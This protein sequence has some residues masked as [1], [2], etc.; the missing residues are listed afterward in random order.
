M[1]GMRPPPAI[2]PRPGRLERAGLPSVPTPMTPQATMTRRD[3]RS[4]LARGALAAL[5]ALTVGA[6]ACAG[7]R[8]PGGTLAELVAAGAFS[9]GGAPAEAAQDRPLRL[10]GEPRPGVVT[11]DDESRPAVTFPAGTWSWRTRVPEDGWLQV[12][13][14]AV[15]GGPLEASVA[16]SNGAEREVLEVGRNDPPEDEPE[17]RGW[18]D[19][20]ADLSRWAGRQVTLDFTVRRP[21]A[22]GAAPDVAWGPVALTAPR[23]VGK[24]DPPNV[25]F[26]LVDTLRHD[27]TTPYGYARDTTPEI[28]RLLARRGTVLENAYSQAPWTLPSVVSFMTSRYPG[29]ILGSDPASYGIPPGVEPIAAAFAALGYRTGAFIGNP[30]VHAGN[31]FARGFETFYS[32]SSPEAITRHGE[33]LNRRALPWLRAHQAERF[34]AYVHYVDPH[35][36]YDD[37]DVVGGRSRLF[38]DPGGMPPTYLQGV[39]AGKLYPDNLE[40]EVRHF[41]A[42]YDTEVHWVDGAI[43]KLLESLPPEVLAH[44]LVVLTADHGEELHD[45]G[46]WKHGQT[47]YEDQIHVPL[48]V[49][50]DGRIQA[51][52]RLSGTVRLVDLLPTLVAA[53]GGRPD[54]SWQGRDLLGPFEGRAPLPRLEAFAQRLQ[55]GPLRAALVLDGRKL[56]LFNRR[57]PF[58]PQDN[59]QASLYRLNLSRM[60]GTELYDLR[61]DPVE[62][63][64][65]LAPDSRPDPGAAPAA[66]DSGRTL[67]V[68]DSLL[69]AHVA[70]TFRFLRALVDSLPAGRRLAGELVFERPPSQVIPLFLSDRDRATS[71]GTTVSFDLVG[72]GRAKGF[73]IAGEPGALLS[74][75]LTLDGEPLA[76]ARLRVGAGE[77]F[78]GRRVEPGALL[79]RAFPAAS[80]RP[81]LRLWAYAGGSEPAA[82]ANPETRKGLEALGYVQ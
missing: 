82:A 80:D 19:F 33:S 35:D 54:P 53:A 47:V 48:I 31:G 30:I 8:P 45:H 68:L 36:P 46:G 7:R 37:P 52:R 29:E 72:E 26:I 1:I 44:T 58:T 25:L 13:V 3:S 5:L 2:M 10:S 76:P 24:T 17:V 39:Y 42:L 21:G 27:H 4:F 51:A 18:I 61:R 75:N 50:W 34:F 78:T 74:A 66:E 22:P 67:A 9:A 16:L 55:V 65:L 6:G 38:D 81:G 32:P 11:L 69:Q 71:A 28:E 14:G 49:R 56:I 15:D 77:P 43:G 60:R 20:G 73:A 59:L 41:T 57:E 62:R 63:Q 23:P 40:R 79:T 70:R 64:D 12:G